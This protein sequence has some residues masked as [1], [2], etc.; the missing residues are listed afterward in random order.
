MK[1]LLSLLTLMTLNTGFAQDGDLVLAN[2][3][4]IATFKNYN[5]QAYG[6]NVEAP[7]TLSRLNV[8]FKTLT[9]DQ[10]LDNGLL[11]ASFTE[12]SALCNYSAIL[13]AD[14]A[15]STIRLVE[16]K[17]Y[18]PDKASDCA[19]GKAVLDAA[20]E[21]N[22]YLYWGHPHNLTILAPAEGAETLCENKL[23]GIN[24]VVTGRIRN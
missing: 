14:N 21:S 9:T 3:K 24:F 7:A 1:M 6:P 10:S 17:A 5:C 22:S 15:A 4:W 16:S 18:S 23:V 20:F 11:K 13:L 8:V 19:A 2:E 12:D